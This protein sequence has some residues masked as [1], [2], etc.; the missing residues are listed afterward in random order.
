LSA[1]KRAY[2]DAAESLARIASEL[3]QR[4]QEREALQT[5][6]ARSRELQGLITKEEPV[7]AGLIAEL[8][9]PLE[10]REQL[11]SQLKRVCA[12]D[13][14]LGPQTLELEELRRKQ[15]ELE[16]TREQVRRQLETL[17]Q[18]CV[19]C[20]KAAQRIEQRQNR[21]RLL[22][23]QHD[24]SAQLAASEQLQGRLDLLEKDLALLPALDAKAVDQLRDTEQC[25]RTA[26]TRAESVAA[27]I[28]VL[29]AGQPVLLDGQPLDTGNRRMLSEAAVLQVGDD[30]EVRVLP[31][32]GSSN[33]EAQLELE[34]A[35][36]ALAS[37][38]ERWTVAT[39][40]E[41]ATA[42][43]RRSDLLAERDRLLEQR[44]SEDQ[45]A[46]RQRLDTLQEGLESLPGEPQEA[47]SLCV[48]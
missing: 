44:G 39:V 37:D 8:R 31:G 5:R 13:S 12:L 4:Q 46:I 6:L 36:S 9:Q 40:E 45:A 47:A 26:Q 14:R 18:T 29:R 48:V 24:L 25:V 35:R 7:L 30:V 27:G 2:E 42:E 22:H 23:Q 34:A 41:A 32:G 20:Q 43:R 15:P 17:Q 3:P 19:A 11:Q 28:E 33:E 1:D 21:V 16:S 38:L 10:D